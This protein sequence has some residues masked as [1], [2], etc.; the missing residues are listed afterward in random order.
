[1]A[2]IQSS[3]G[4]ELGEA[5]PGNGQRVRVGKWAIVGIVGFG[6]A[7]FRTDQALLMVL[8]CR[9]MTWKRREG[10]SPLVWVQSRKL[11]GTELGPERL[12]WDQCQN[13][14][15]LDPYHCWVQYRVGEAQAV[16][17]GL[18]GWP[19]VLHRPALLCLCI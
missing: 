4:T 10:R 8:P 16:N 1:M 17:P 15:R 6:T 18:R 3:N 7:L 13:L 12:P 14:S 2:F 11:E 9:Q 5:G 19:W